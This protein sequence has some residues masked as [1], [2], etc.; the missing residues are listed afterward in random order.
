MSAAALPTVKAK[1]PLCW[2]VGCP[3]GLG[4]GCT[5]PKAIVRP[6]GL[7]VGSSAGGSGADP[8]GRFPGTAL[9]PAASVEREVARREGG[10]SAEEVGRGAAAGQSGGEASPG[11]PRRSRASGA[12]WKV[13]S[14]S[15]WPRRRAAAAARAAGLGAAPQGSGRPPGHGPGA[16]PALRDSPRATRGHLAVPKEAA[17]RQKLPHLRPLSPCRAAGWVPVPLGL[18]PPNLSL[19]PRA[20]ESLMSGPERKPPACC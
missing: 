12:Q 16:L 14:A 17:S 10:S 13:G 20:F 9:T 1:F 7:R 8:R 2:F 19:G 6:E 11:F 3:L 4:L 15:G 18:S 5:F